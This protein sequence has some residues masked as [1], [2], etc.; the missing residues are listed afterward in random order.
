MGGWTFQAGGL[1][2]GGQRRKKWA[3]YCFL[4]AMLSA[5][6]LILSLLLSSTLHS[7]GNKNQHRPRQSFTSFY[8]TVL[9]GIFS[10]LFNYGFVWDRA[11]VHECRCPERTDECDWL[12]LE[13]QAH[14]CGS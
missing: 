14:I 9:P 7:E 1:D 8:V 12:P 13:S 10:F 6:P 2:R 5:Q 4:I 3:P 11:C